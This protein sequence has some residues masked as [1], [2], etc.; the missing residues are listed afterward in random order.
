MQERE[1]QFDF[2]PVE[3]FVH[4]RIHPGTECATCDGSCLC[5]IEEPDGECLGGPME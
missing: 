3:V 5:A 2:A 4:E 1:T